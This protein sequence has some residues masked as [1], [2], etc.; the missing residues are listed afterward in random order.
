[1]KSKHLSDTN[2]PLSQRTYDEFKKGLKFGSLKWKSIPKKMKK[3]IHSFEEFRK[4]RGFERIL[5]KR[6]WKGKNYETPM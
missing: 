4:E 6:A 3:T 1:M 2:F 5:R